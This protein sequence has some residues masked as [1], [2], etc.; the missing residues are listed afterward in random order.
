MVV[1]IQGIQ[2]EFLEQ[3]SGGDV[4]TNGMSYRYA[5][6]GATAEVVAIA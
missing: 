2:P 6:H 1:G 4:V 5:A 3:V